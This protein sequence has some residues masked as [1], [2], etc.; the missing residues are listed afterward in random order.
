MLEQFMDVCILALQSGVTMGTDGL[1]YSYIG[2]GYYIEQDPIDRELDA[3]LPE[4]VIRRKLELYYAENPASME[5]DM[6]WLEQVVLE[7]YAQV[8]PIVHRYN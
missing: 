4:C 6:E 7:S 2:D 1:F 5:M 3:E 8:I